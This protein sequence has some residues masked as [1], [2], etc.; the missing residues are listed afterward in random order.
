MTS[1]TAEKGKKKKKGGE[2]KG[3]DIS[4]SAL[5]RL[6]IPINSGASFL[7]RLCLKAAT[8]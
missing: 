5:G 3:D 8:V 7:T 6:N 2:K 4:F 1:S